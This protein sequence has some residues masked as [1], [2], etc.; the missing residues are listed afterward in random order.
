MRSGRPKLIG[1]GVFAFFLA[2]AAF[3]QGKGRP[4]AVLGRRRNHL[5][6]RLSAVLTIGVLRRLLGGILGR[7]GLLRRHDAEIMLR[8]LKII[9][10]RDAVSGTVGIA[11]KLQVFFV[12]MGG[13]T[14]NFYF[15]ARG[16]KGAVGVESA[17]AA[18]AAAAT[19]AAIIVVVLR[20]PAASARAFHEC[21]I[22]LCQK[23][24]FVS[25]RS[26]IAKCCRHNPKF[27]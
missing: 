6:L 22:M 15:R 16:I 4:I 25:L 2:L 21:T 11:G 23:N 12:D 19:T 24:A 20:P 26:G 3:S 1:F 27:V 9:L 8:M 5:G 13:R 18:I 10:G 14:A 17:A 7:L